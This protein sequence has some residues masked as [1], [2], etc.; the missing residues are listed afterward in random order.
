M[1]NIGHITDIPEET[2]KEYHVSPDISLFIVNKHD[3]LFAYLNQCPHIGV[4]LNWNP[5]Q[6][7]NHDHSL[8]QCATHGA[9]FMIETGECISGPC[10]RQA[11]TPIPLIQDTDGQLWVKATDLPN[12]QPLSPTDPS[13]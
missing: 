4:E 3:R 7:L 6:F 5:D 9:L 1:I 10:L 11:L 13:R 12:D 2:S 8:I